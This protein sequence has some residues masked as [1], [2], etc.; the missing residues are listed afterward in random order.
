[1]YLPQCGIRELC[2]RI[3]YKFIRHVHVFSEVEEKPQEA[4]E[5]D[6]GVKLKKRKESEVRSVP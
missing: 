2:G 5:V 1:M 3:S 4:E 6:F